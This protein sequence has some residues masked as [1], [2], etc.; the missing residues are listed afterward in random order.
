MATVLRQ[1]AKLEL[2][3]VLREQGYATYANLLNLFD[4]YLTDDPEVVGYMLP[5]K[6]KI[7]LNQGLTMG[8]VSTVVRHEILHEYL[9]HMERNNAFHKLNLKYIPV[10]ELSNI[11]ADFEISNKG[12]TEADKREM[13]RLKLNGQILK[14]LVTELDRPGWE[15]LTYEEM[16]QRLL[17]ENEATSEA[18]E[19]LLQQISK[20]NKKDL[21]D[22]QDELEKMSGQSSEEKQQ[23]QGKA[24]TDSTQDS[25]EEASEKDMGSTASEEAGE[26]SDSKDDKAT[27]AAKDIANKASELADEVQDQVQ[28][29]DEYQQSNGQGGFADQKDQRDQLDIAAKVAAIEKAFKD[30]KTKKQLLDEVTSNRQKEKAEK[31]ARDIQRFRGSGLSKFKMALNRFI[32]N[33]IVSAREET[34]TRIDPRYEDSEFIL[35]GQVD[36]EQQHIPSINVYWDASGS[37]SNPAKTAAAKKAIETLNK[38]VRSGEIKMHVWYHGTKVASTYAAAGGGN[39]SNV[40]LEHIHQTKPDNVIVITDGDLSYDDIPTTV[41]GAVWMLFYDQR[42]SGLMDN[43]HGKCE[44]KYFDIE[45]R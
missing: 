13:K 12:Y 18:L 20:L 22:L 10:A 30:L 21:E 9:T 27:K 6:A 7:V 14:G 37:F 45:Y 32:Q 29:M 23:D 1:D 39:R 40:V 38:Y 33:E 31:E 8:Q 44:T 41:P 28:K 3:R 19:Q 43:L 25:G 16:Y 35:P 2:I 15:N 36:K 11:A 24:D 26:S 34:Y 4:V 5:G 17:D 42:S